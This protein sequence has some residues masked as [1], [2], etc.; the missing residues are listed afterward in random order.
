MIKQSMDLRGLLAFIAILFVVRQ[1]GLAKPKKTRKHYKT[2]EL[3]IWSFPILCHL[4]ESTFARLPR[5]KIR[6]FIYE[7]QLFYLDF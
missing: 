5:I 6:Q 2:F 1:H 4:D 7:G 3:V